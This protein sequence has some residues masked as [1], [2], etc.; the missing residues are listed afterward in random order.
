MEEIKFPAVKLGLYVL[1]EKKHVAWM[2]SLADSFLR[3][4]IWI[5]VSV[6]QSCLTPLRP[7]GLQHTRLL[8]PWNVPE[9]N[10]GVGCCFLRQGIFPIQRLNLHLLHWQAHALLLSHWGNPNQYV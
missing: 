5:V 2:K 4:P 3:S 10:T 8:S 1:L 9:K 6:A 7:D